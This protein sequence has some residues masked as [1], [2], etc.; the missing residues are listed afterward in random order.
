MS[1]LNTSSF[2]SGVLRKSGKLSS[3]EG[4]LESLGNLM[5]E[6]IAVS[7]SH[8]RRTGRGPGGGGLKAPSVWTPELGIEGDANVR[9]MAALHTRL[10]A[11]CVAREEEVARLKTQIHGRQEQMHQ[12][13]QKLQS[14]DEAEQVLKEQIM[15]ASDQCRLLRS[16]VHEM[17]GE[18]QEARGLSSLIRRA[19]DQKQGE[20][21]SGGELVSFSLIVTCSSIFSY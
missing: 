16:Q 11:L 5:D 21:Q 20:I 8:L 6:G 10:E 1:S 4:T 14:M 13:T 7:S 15:E 19:F 9:V 18:T 3:G 17:D 2:G 12:C